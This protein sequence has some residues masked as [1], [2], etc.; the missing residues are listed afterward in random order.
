VELSGCRGLQSLLSVTFQHEPPFSNGMET[1]LIVTVFLW[2][3]CPRFIHQ[4]RGGG[5]QVGASAYHR[6]PALLC[7]LCGALITSGLIE[8]RSWFPC[9]CVQ[10]TQALVMITVSSCEPGNRPVTLNL[11][12]RSLVCGTFLFIYCLFLRRGYI[13]YFAPKYITRLVGDPKR[14]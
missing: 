3:R 5:E 14:H 9:P 6:I 13:A 10:D 4:W 11:F 2:L 1:F 8:F 7:A 12:P